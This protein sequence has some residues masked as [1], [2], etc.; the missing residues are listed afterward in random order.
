MKRDARTGKR[1]AYVNLAAFA[2][3]TPLSTTVGDFGNASVGLLR[4]PTISVW[5]PTIERRFPI[6]NGK[7]LRLQFQAY[8]LFNQVEFTMLNAALTF[9]GV[10]NE[11]QTSTTAGTHNTVMNPRQLGLTVK[12]D[13]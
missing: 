5:D 3:P 10:N 9:A 1:H 2:M 7:G 8:N 13:F 4:N 11:T 6:R 12:F